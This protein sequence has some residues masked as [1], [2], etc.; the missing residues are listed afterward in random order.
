LNASH[1]KKLPQ[2]HRVVDV[3]AFPATPHFP[4][5]EETHAPLGE[6]YLNY[7]I[8]KADFGRGVLLAIHG[9]LHLL[10]YRH[11]RETDAARMEQKEHVLWRRIASLD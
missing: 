4:H 2:G 10:G 9:V 1:G 11:E 3:L 5:P 8:L 7:D 6:M